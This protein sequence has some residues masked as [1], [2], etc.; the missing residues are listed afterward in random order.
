MGGISSLD[1]YSIGIWSC[2]RK[3][4]K[5]AVVFN[6]DIDAPDARL[7]AAAPDLLTALKA[8]LKTYDNPAYGALGDPC[9]VAR[10]V[11]AKAEVR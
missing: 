11:I 1:E 7:I 8:M 2:D 3:W 10:A 6:Q 4:P 5:I 9:D